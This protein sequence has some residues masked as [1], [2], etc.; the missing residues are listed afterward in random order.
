MDH[1]V[2]RQVFDPSGKYVGTVG[3]AISHAYFEGIY[4]DI[5][6]AEGDTILILHAIRA[7]TLIR[8]PRWMR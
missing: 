7:I 8:H 3:A 5:R 4:R 2:T 6:F 1:P